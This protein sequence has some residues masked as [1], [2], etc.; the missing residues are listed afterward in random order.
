MDL[1]NLTTPSLWDPL[2]VS[3]IKQPLSHFLPFCMNDIGS[4]CLDLQGKQVIR[5]TFISRPACSCQFAVAIHVLLSMFFPH[6]L[7]LFICCGFF[8]ALGCTPAVALRNWEHSSA[9]NAACSGKRTIMFEGCLFAISL[10]HFL[11]S[12]PLLSLLYVLFLSISVS[13]SSCLLFLGTAASGCVSDLFLGCW[14]LSVHKMRLLSFWA[15][16]WDHLR[17][18][19]CGS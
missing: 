18:S 7:L 17:W 14:D 2:Y 11:W 12:P 16:Y 3:Q 6:D 10:N 19:P 1:A 9:W 4:W 8:A 13:L 5:S 15:N